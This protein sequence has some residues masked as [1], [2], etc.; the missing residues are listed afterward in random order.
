MKVQYDAFSFP[1]GYSA[2]NAVG[3]RGTYGAFGAQGGGKTGTPA[4]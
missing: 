2:A 4:S 1:H 3:D